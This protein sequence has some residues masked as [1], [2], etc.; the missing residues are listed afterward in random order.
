MT[1]AP[2]RAFFDY[3]SPTTSFAGQIPVAPKP[4]DAANLAPLDPDK[5]PSDVD[6]PIP[7]A[8]AVLVRRETTPSKTPPAARPNA[9]SP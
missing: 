3:H 5:P 4:I 1:A 9:K 2:I 6:P 7:N 8:A